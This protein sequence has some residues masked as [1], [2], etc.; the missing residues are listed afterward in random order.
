MNMPSPF[1][2]FGGWASDRSKISD[3][4]QNHASGISDSPSVDR[5][6]DWLC[7]QCGETSV[8]GHPCSGIT[9]SGLCCQHTQFVKCLVYVDQMAFDVE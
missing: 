6:D 8:Q 2:M 5:A 1:K 4:A 7:C 3:S 9:R